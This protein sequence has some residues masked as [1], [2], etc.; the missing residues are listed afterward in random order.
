VER[1]QNVDPPKMSHKQK[2]AFWIN[3]YNALLM[4]V[5]W[6]S[7]PPWVVLVREINLLCEKRKKIYGWGYCNI[8]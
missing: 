2:L 8:I 1:L 7:S 3:I 4:H 5:S 6:S